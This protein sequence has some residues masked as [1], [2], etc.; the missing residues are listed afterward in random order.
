MVLWSCWAVAGEGCPHLTSERQRLYRQ[1]AFAHGYIHGYEQGFHLGNQDL[2]LARQAR[3]ITKFE[4]YR[5]ATKD[6]R[7][8]FGSRNAFRSGYRDGIVVGYTDARSG[9]TF[10]AIYEARIAAGSLE[11]LAEAPPEPDQHFE[12]GFMDG[13]IA[14]T[15]Q[16]VGDGRNHTNYRPQQAECTRSPERL[17]L[18]ETYCTGYLGGFRFGYSDGYINNE[19]LEVGGKD[20]RHTTLTAAQK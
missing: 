10:R 3:D 12:L 19:Q 16:G 1:S 15:I 11:K 18:G 20:G 8:Q 2:Q 13:Y 14:G 9:H 6:Y 7:S 5:Q 17:S 4:E